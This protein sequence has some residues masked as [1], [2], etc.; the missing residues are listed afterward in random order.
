MLKRKKK[1]EKWATHVI[2]IGTEKKNQR[3]MTQWMR[4]THI[5]HLMVH[6]FSHSSFWILISVPSCCSFVCVLLAYYECWFLCVVYCFGSCLWTKSIRRT[7]IMHCSI[8]SV[9]CENVSL[10][11]YGCVKSKPKPKQKQNY[12]FYLPFAF[13]GAKWKKK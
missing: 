13:V 11:C 9:V 2:C 5:L 10:Q 8:S 12:D 1:I 4:C 6:F 3:L 7:S